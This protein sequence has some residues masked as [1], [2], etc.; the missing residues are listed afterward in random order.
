MSI[1]ALSSVALAGTIHVIAVALGRMPRILAILAISAVLIVLGGFR[2]RPRFGLV[3]AARVLIQQFGQ[4]RI[5]I[6]SY[7][8][9]PL[10]T[11]L[12]GS[13]RISFATIPI[14]HGMTR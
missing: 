4:F 7:A 10:S 13:I 3:L 6:D 12:S 14:C 2:V 8:L 1:T 9:G 5:P 11:R